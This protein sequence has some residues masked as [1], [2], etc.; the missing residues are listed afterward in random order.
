MTSSSVTCPKAVI[1]WA[2]FSTQAQAQSKDPWNIVLVELLSGIITSNSNLPSFYVYLVRALNFLF[3]HGAFGNVGHEH[4]SWS[5]WWQYMTLILTKRRKNIYIFHVTGIDP[6]QWYFLSLFIFRFSEYSK[7]QSHQ[8]A[9]IYASIELL[10]APK[11]T[12][13]FENT[14]SVSSKTISRTSP[15]HSFGMNKKVTQTTLAY[16]YLSFWFLSDFYLASRII[17][18][19]CLLILLASPWYFYSSSQPSSL[20]N[21]VEISSVYA[22][23]FC[24]SLL[25]LCVLLFNWNIA[26]L[27]HSKSNKLFL[28]RLLF[29]T[30]VTI[31]S[32]HPFDF[33]NLWLGN[34]PIEMTHVFLIDTILNHIDRRFHQVDTE[35]V[36]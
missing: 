29:V 14:S 21:S 12:S 10:P 7:D 5:S 32:Y 8:Q 19:T 1:S 2:L 33:H 20:M 31:H 17:P 23:F 15:T 4:V 26:I 36:W 18:F 35:T 27:Q 16:V 6:S 28:G 22:S 24:T 9:R 3:A 34:E 30:T 11:H 25:F 13:T